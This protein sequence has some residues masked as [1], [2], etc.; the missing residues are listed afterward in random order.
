M[1][2][3]I[4]TCDLTPVVEENIK[5]GVIDATI[6]QQPFRQGFGSVKLLFDYLIA[7]EKPSKD[8]IHTEIEIKLKYNL[9]R[10]IE[11]YFFRNQ[12]G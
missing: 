5:K 9:I 4:V 10:R 1:S 3:N 7:N 6:C 11:G 8:V 12:E 2:F